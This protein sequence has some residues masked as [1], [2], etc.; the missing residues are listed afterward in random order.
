MTTWATS[1]AASRTP[2]CTSS[3]PICRILDHNCFNNRDFEYRASLD[4][5]FLVHFAGRTKQQSMEEFATRLSANRYL[6]PESWLSQLRIV[7][8][9]KSD[10]SV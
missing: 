8:P 5:H 7:E 4:E 1:P 10:E 9:T 2:W 6:T 3:R